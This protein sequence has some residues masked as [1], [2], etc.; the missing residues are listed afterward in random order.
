MFTA[1]RILVSSLS[2][3]DASFAKAGEVTVPRR[4]F[5]A[6]SFRL[7]GRIT[8]ETEN[9]RLLSSA[10]ELTFVPQGISYRT[11]ILEDSRIY[12]VHFNTVDRYPKPSPFVVAPPYPV[13][14]RNLFAG[15]FSRYRVGMEH[16]LTCLS[17]FYEILAETVRAL[18]ASGET[19]SDSPRL[20]AVRAQIDRHFDDPGMTVAALAA[21]AGWSEAYFRRAFRKAFGVPPLEYIRQVRLENAKALLRTG[22]YSVTET[23]M[24]CGFDSVSYFS[25]TFRKTVGVTPSAY[26]ERFLS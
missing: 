10:G 20:R 17:I 4:D 2:V 9:E 15:L 23:A 14:L 19:G 5:H 1:P 21:H 7:S 6:L 18:P 24:R 12:V 25:Y 26:R 16:D 3:F 11:E 22:Y 13:V 8:V